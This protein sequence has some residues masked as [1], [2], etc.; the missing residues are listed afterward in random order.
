MRVHAVISN[1]TESALITLYVWNPC[2]YQSLRLD[3]E[4][5]EVFAYTN[6]VTLTEPLEDAVMRTS[7]SLD[8]GPIKY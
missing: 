4:H 2:Y 5:S 6:E 1:S 8:C 3:L 7:T